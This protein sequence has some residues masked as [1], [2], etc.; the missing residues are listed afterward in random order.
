MLS[1]VL[2]FFK[3]KF[4]KV[5]L[6]QL[7]CITVDFYTVDDLSEAKV[8]LLSDIE[9]L[10]SSVRFPHV[11]QRRDGEARLAREAD[12]LIALFNCL[13]E[14]KL[15]DS[16]P[17]YVSADPDRIPSTRLFEGDM[18][19]IMVMLEK[20]EH[21]VDGYG[22]ALSAI[23]RD[24]TALQS[25][26]IVPDQFPPLP[27]PALPVPT[28]ASQVR[29]AQQPQRQP[30]AQRMT[31][32][33][34][35]STHIETNIQSSTEVSEQRQDWAAHASTPNASTNRYAALAS[36]TDDEAGYERVQSKKKRPRVR[37]P[38][39]QSSAMVNSTRQ[40]QQQAGQQQQQRRR[41]SVFGKSVVATRIAA[42]RKLKKR[43]AV[44]CIDNVDAVCACSDIEL[45]V[46]AMSVEVVSCF[47]VKSRL[48]RKT[49][50]D[51]NGEG[52][53]AFRLC[54]Y[55]EDTHRLMNPEVWPDSV[56]ISEWYFKSPRNVP[57]EEQEQSKRRRMIGNE[58]HVVDADEAGVT[59]PEPSPP[60]PFRVVDSPIG[61]ATDVAAIALVGIGQ[62][63]D[64]DNDNDDTILVQH[65]DCLTDHGGEQ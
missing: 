7:K 64:N 18:N 42:A 63:N 13:D 26:C 29:P 27:A 49:R 51:D 21:K 22:S 8:R 65:M 41:P 34:G 40:Y 1:D 38:Q 24:V 15:L 3:N 45:F 60:A 33:S 44:L 2:C 48:Q 36:T 6:K 57:A 16:L 59:D 50:T 62:D 53:K 58:D 23:T 12:D 54:I 35:N 17:R 43:K 47:E 4:S 37:T 25:K 19:V 52:H 28:A 56:I 31:A 55:A 46:N 32:A 20:L 14:H 5:P 61:S 11:P 10:K 9:A 39:Q 30:P